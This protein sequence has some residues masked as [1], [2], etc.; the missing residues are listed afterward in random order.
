MPISTSRWR[1][2]YYNRVG[3]VGQEFTKPQLISATLDWDKSSVMLLL[4]PSTLLQVVGHV[5]EC[6]FIP[7]HCSSGLGEF[8]WFVVRKK[9]RLREYEDHNNCVG[10]RIET[11]LDDCAAVSGGGAFLTTVC[12]DVAMTFVEET[13][14]CLRRKRG[15]DTPCHTMPFDKTGD[16]GWRE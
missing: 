15:R 11:W 2:P 8:G 10:R 5:G 16:G 14:W 12:V 13:Q 1:W 4:A 3:G 6:P 9:A 7:W